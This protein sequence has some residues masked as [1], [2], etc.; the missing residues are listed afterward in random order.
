ML[1]VRP[2]QM[3][4]LAMLVLSF[5]FIGQTKTEK[6]DDDKRPDYINLQ[7]G[8]ELSKNEM[9]PVGFLHDLHTKALDGK[10]ATCHIEKNNIFVFKFKRTDEKASMDLYHDNC[11]ACHLEKKASKEKAGPVTADC[12]SCHVTGTSK[13]SSWEKIN[14][15]RSLHFRHE[16]SG[17]IKGQDTLN[18]ENCS[19]CHHQYN[20]KTNEIF[21]VKGQEESCA[22]CH[23]PLKQDN[24]RPIGQASHDACVKCHQTLETKDI[25]AGPVTCNGCHDT[26]EQQKIKTV[27]NIPRLK[28]NQPDEVAITGWIPGKQKTKTYMNGVAF[29]HKFH[30]TKTDTCKA[31][32][33]ETLKKC[34]DCHTAD[35]GEVKGGFV[36]LEKA[37]HSKDNTKSCVG[38]HKEFTK[39]SDCAGCHFQAPAKKDNSDSCKTCH[40]LEQA[41]L[42]SMEPGKFVKKAVADI[43]L[44]YKPV[45]VD[46][47][48]ETIVIDDLSNKYKPASFPHRKMVKAIFKRVEK[49][50]MAKAFHTD[51]ARLCMGCHHN[52]P[53]TLEPPQCAS[54]HSK[55]GPG[56][57]GRP[58]LT[59][60]FHGQCITCHQKMEVQSVV[61]TDCVKCHEEKK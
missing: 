29:N 51:Q 8:P 2:F 28:R 16:S 59:G 36:S 11:I 10:C 23:K 48:P 55:K 34:N 58:G 53:K 61:A 12:R 9:E 46:K 24:I 38:C 60:A 18:K 35:G 43:S 21:Y 52:S 45:A 27:S 6:R 32:H 20:E 57:D 40:N 13:K 44:G 54:C 31:C 39:K 22:Y 3:I 41:K 25:D 26:K 4:I 30:E 17:Q 47:I 50:D 42:Q 14:F 5:P 49:S 15:N 33:H 56:V 37:M 1:R 7:L 19:A